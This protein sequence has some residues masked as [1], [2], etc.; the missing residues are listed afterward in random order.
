M[1]V[2]TSGRS[3]C[4]T[5]SSGISQSWSKSIVHCNHATGL[6]QP[7]SANPLVDRLNMF[8]TLSTDECDAVAAITNNWRVAH[9]GETLN[10]E[11]GR[12]D[13]G[14]RIVRAASPTATAIC[15]MADG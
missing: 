15:P 1:L 10:H 3:D 8:I 13:R 7:A 2:I 5:D 4:E 12:P 14:Y 11:G 6:L 9:A